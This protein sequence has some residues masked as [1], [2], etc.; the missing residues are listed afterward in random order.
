VAKYRQYDEDNNPIDGEYTQ[1]FKEQY[2]FVLN[3][4]WIS[5]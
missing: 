5:I 3:D 4:F 1:I 2:Q